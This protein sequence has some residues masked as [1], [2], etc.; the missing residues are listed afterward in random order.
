MGNLW[1][2]ICGLVAL[3]LWCAGAASAAVQVLNITVDRGRDGEASGLVSYHQTVLVRLQLSSFSDFKCIEITDPAGKKC[4]VTGSSCA[5]SDQ[6]DEQLGLVCY[7]YEA[8]SDQQTGTVGFRETFMAAA[9]TAGAYSIQVQSSE[10]SPVT[11]KTAATVAVPSTGPTL[12]SPSA[13]AVLS[14]TAPTFTWK[15]GTGTTNVLQVR[16]EG[17]TSFTSESTDDCGQVWRVS[18]GTNTSA[19]Y[20]YDGGATEAALQPGSCYFWQMS[21]TKVDKQSSNPTT[22]LSTTQVARRRFSIYTPWTGLPDLPGGFVF[23]SVLWGDWSSYS[24]AIRSYS[25]DMNTQAWPEPE[26][27]YDPTWAQDGSVLVFMRDGTGLWVDHRDGKPAQSL[28]WYAVGD[29]NV[30]PDVRRVA[31]VGMDLTKGLYQV[32]IGTLD[33]KKNTLLVQAADQNG[34]LR[35]P[36]WSP[37]GTQIAYVKSDSSKQTSELHLIHPDG[38]SDQLVSASGLAGYSGYTVA[39]DGVPLLVARHGKAGRRLPGQ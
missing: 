33:G 19:V 37:D 16:E 8:A 6:D 34:A 18:T 31:Y 1:R 22:T 39:L 23:S 13:D 10:G 29:P 36:V 20:D 14:S 9:P 30:S 7:I 2:H 35:W 3:S 5:F 32:N 17:N 38:T 4:T 15:N 12:Q 11:V 25:Q 27:S 26:C 21:S 24:D 28:P